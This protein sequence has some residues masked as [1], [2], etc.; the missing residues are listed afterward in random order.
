MVRRLK[1]ALPLPSRHIRLCPESHEAAKN[2][3]QASL[4]ARLFLILFLL[5][6]ELSDCSCTGIIQVLLVFF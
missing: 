3:E 2:Q 5:F 6:K 1:L 4:V